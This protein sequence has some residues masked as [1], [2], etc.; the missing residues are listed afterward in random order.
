LA[1]QTPEALY[2]SLLGELKVRLLWID[3]TLSGE[4]GLHGQVAEEFCFLQ[5]RLVAELIAIASLVA[6][7][8]IEATRSA[9]LQKAYEAD[10]ILNALEKLHPDFYPRPAV[11]TMLG[12]GR[13]HFDWFEG[14]SLAKPDLVALWRR[15]GGILHKGG[16]AAL[17]VPGQRTDFNR[18][19]VEGTVLRIRNLLSTHAIRGFDE[20]SY[21][22]CLMHFGSD[23][24]PEFFRARA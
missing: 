6:H 20:R 14:P 10:R 23:R 18:D 1:K 16:L 19:E 11:H 7:G 4:I 5:L 13:H 2:A 21:S 12:P 22:I 9:K 3:H 15:C 17:V 8:D 24:L